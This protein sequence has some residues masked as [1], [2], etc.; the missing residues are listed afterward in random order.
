MSA[1]PGSARRRALV[2]SPVLVAALSAGAGAVDG[3]AHADAASLA[4][5]QTLSAPTVVTQQVVG[6]PRLTLTVGSRR[7]APGVYVPANLR[8]TAPDGSAV[9]GAAVTIWMTPPARPRLHIPAVHVVTARNGQVALR[10]RMSVSERISATATYA[11]RT[12]RSGA[13]LRGG[14]VSAPQTPTVT[15]VEPM[16]AQVLAEVASLAGRPYVWGAAGPRAFDCSGLVRFVF[17]HVAH[18]S[19]PHNAQAQYDVAHHEPRSAIRPGDLVFFFAGGHAYH[20]GIYAGHGMMWHA[21]HPGDHVRLAPI[22]TTS[23]AAGRV[24]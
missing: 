10:L 16:S 22:Y 5:S 7:S 12:L 21:P 14:T 13:L 4:A 24:L 8:L 18:R 19:L 6:P 15:I 9:A 1:R 2:A 20:V 11:S 23:W 17:A 3:V